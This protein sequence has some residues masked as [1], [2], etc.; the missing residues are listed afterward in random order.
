[1]LWRQ[2]VVMVAQ[3]KHESLEDTDWILSGVGGHCRQSL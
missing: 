1:M 2:M 3:A